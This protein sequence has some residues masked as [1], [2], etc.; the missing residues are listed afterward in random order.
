MKL[1]V[2]TVRDEKVHLFLPPF[3]ARNKGEAVR[4]FGD[5]A[6]NKE[7]NFAKY[8][9][10]FTLYELGTFDDEDGTFTLA[11]PIR[12]ASVSEVMPDIS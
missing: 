8:P 4:S 10:D 2:F 11:M 9:E 6:R 3:Y 5:A 7:H 12:L 1:G